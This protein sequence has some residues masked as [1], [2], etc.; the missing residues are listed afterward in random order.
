MI[1]CTSEF[2]PASSESSTPNFSH[3][4]YETFPDLY[5]HV[6]PLPP[7]FSTFYHNPSFSA[8]HAKQ[9]EAFLSGR[10]CCGSGKGLIESE[11]ND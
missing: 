3:R 2:L 10:I 11:F 6:D 4:T 9:L 5:V 8:A 1:A 7:S